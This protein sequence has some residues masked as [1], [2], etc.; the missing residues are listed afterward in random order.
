MSEATTEF[1]DTCQ[2]IFRDSCS[3][4]RVMRPSKLGIAFEHFQHT[5]QR[6]K[7]PRPARR[8]NNAHSARTRKAER[9]CSTEQWRADEHLA[10]FLFCLNSYLRPP[11]DIVNSMKISPFDLIERHESKAS[12][13]RG[14]TCR[15]A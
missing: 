15:A 5:E 9:D 6:R 8:G 10:P 2:T 7:R 1:P 12:M 14:E 11:T 4:D 3:Q 13:T